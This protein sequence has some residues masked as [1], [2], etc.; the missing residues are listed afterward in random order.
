MKKAYKK[1][2]DI[3]LSCQS[4]AHVITAYNYIHNFRILFGTEDGCQKLTENL[5]EKCAVKRKLVSNI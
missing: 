4:E 3:I 1:A 2:I 5:M